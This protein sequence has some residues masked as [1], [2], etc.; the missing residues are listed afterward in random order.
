MKLNG[1]LYRELRCQ[2]CR[3]LICFEYIFAGRIYFACPKC[4]HPNVF[5]FK[6]LKTAQNKSII[7]QEFTKLNNKG[8]DI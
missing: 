3:K 4:K 6:Y 2:N 5:D 8:G 1:K 7:N